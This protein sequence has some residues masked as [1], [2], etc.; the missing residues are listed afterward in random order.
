MASPG[1]SFTARNI[2]NRA[3]RRADMKNSNY[4]NVE[5]QFEVLNECYT[6]MYDILVTA[7][8][9][10]YMVQ[11]YFIAL[12][13][14][15]YMYD[16]PDD[17][18]KGMGVDYNLNVTTTGWVSLKPFTEMERNGLSGVIGTLPSGQVRMRYVP[19]PPIFTDDADLID[20]VSGW[21]SLIVAMMAISFRTKEETDTAPL[22]RLKS[23][24]IQRIT[25]A[26]QNRDGG[27]PAQV[28]DIYQVNIFLAYASLRYQYSG[29]KIR[30]MNTEI[31]GYAYYGSF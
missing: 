26:S 12:S 25:A 5:E 14:N 11:E 3:L 1:R 27:M 19:V 4:I 20:G 9:E 7:Y 13:P 28:N 18:Y 31:S 16:L 29:N 10:Y 23:Q 24:L 2:I 6:E 8:A 15:T 21:D 22:E 17:F 30:F